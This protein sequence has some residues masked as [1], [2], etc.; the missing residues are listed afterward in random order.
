MGDKEKKL[1]TQDCL[2]TYLTNHNINI[3][4]FSRLMGCS[5]GMVASCF[6]H[7]K[8][9]NGVP[10][11]FTLQA[12]P[13]LNAALPALAAALVAGCVRFGSEETYTNRKGITYDPGTLPQLREL[14]RLVNLTA[15]L[16]RLLGW[17]EK[18]KNAI[19]SEPGSKVYGNI[20]EADV[21]AINSELRA[22]ARMLSG[23]EVE[24]DPAAIAADSRRRGSDSSSE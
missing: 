21:A 9:K 3:L 15:F 12:L 7:H 24:P 23:I 6:L 1:V 13:K 18:K 2:Y 11:V 19:F 5:H 20:T 17:S 10:R 22:V 8:D 14:S 16:M 4:G